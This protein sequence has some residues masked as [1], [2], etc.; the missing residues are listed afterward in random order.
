LGLTAPH[1]QLAD[2]AVR[3]VHLYPA[4][5]WSVDMK[6]IVLVSAALLLGLSVMAVA[7]QLGVSAKWA[8]GRAGH[9]PEVVIHDVN[10]SAIGVARAT[11]QRV[12]PLLRNGYGLLAKG[13]FGDAS[14]S[15]RQALGIDRTCARAW[16][17]LAEACER[18]GKDDDAIQAYRAMIYSKGWGS[19]IN[20]DPVTMMRY[21]LLLS[22]R[23][24]WRE[25]VAAYND[26]EQ[27][28][29][30]GRGHP[31][32]GLRFSETAPDWPTMRAVAH[33]VL[34]I[35]DAYHGPVPSAEKMKHLEEAVKLRPQWPEAQLAYGQA[36]LRQRK[37]DQAQK[38]LT[39]AAKSP[40]RDTAIR[41][42]IG[43]RTIAGHR[44]WDAQKAHEAAAKE[45]GSPDGQK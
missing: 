33:L 16:L 6:C 3:Q 22:K 45:S 37:L 13:Q 27:R 4:E 38:A 2:V 42:G 19:S 25:A 15:F 26:V 20:H 23:G 12:A 32:V 10:P 35:R 9:Q 11:E 44:A 28:S 31:L 29:Q 39:I 24:D 5:E 18:Q 40:D 8:P 21:V 36:L 1:D 7:L 34:G 17:G 43:L 14:S 30:T 41:A